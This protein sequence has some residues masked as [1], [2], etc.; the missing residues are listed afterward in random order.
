MLRKG[1]IRE[2]GGRREEGAQRA[3]GSAPE[4]EEEEE[5]RCCLTGS[6]QKD[7]GK[8]K[9]K[10]PKGE[11]ART[12][13]FRNTTH[14]REIIAGRRNATESRLWLH[15]KRQN[16]TWQHFYTTFDV[17]AGTCNAM[18]RLHSC[19]RLKNAALMGLWQIGRRLE[20]HTLLRHYSQSTFFWNALICGLHTVVTIG[21]LL[22]G[23]TVMMGTP[24]R[25]KS[26]HG[27][28]VQLHKVGTR[29][30]FSFSPITHKWVYQTFQTTFG[31]FGL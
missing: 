29:E 20:N 26:Y 23:K 17:T 3:T 24:A 1:G 12:N 10:E 5:R 13:I 19:M 30:Q 8:A 4:R 27:Q 21:I 22:L 9:W 18:V 25:K 14:W 2:R 31:T 28:T 15:A 7:N 11:N 6:Q 16:Q